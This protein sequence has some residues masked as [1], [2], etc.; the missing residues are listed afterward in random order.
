MIRAKNKTEVQAALNA[1]IEE[2]IVKLEIGLKQLKVQYDMFFNGALPRQP[3]EMRS[4]LN[5]IIRRYENAHIQKY[6]HRFHFN[7]LVGRYN[8]LSE[9]WAKTLR[10]REEGDRRPTQVERPRVRGEQL[11]ARCRVSGASADPEEIRRLYDKFVE[12]HRREGLGDRAI[13]FEKF[14][15]GIDAQARRLRK[16]SGCAEIELW[17]VIQDQKVQLKARPGR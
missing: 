11:V 13:P 15:K 1:Q 3:F 2:D 14:T 17:L 5:R 12:A 6:E 7:T 10:T 9:L 4:Q 16:N 8:T